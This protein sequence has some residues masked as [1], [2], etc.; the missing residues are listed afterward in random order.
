MVFPLIPGA[1][2][3]A[4]EPLALVATISYRPSPVQMTQN[5][6][7]VCGGR[8]IFT[9][10]LRRSALEFSTYLFTGYYYGSHCLSNPLFPIQ[11]SGNSID[12][13]L[14]L[15]RPCNVNPKVQSGLHHA[16]T[17][18]RSCLV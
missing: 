15:I 8:P 14:R 5:V 17:G 11:S 6:W 3:K 9:L 4:G 16:Q 12:Q 2:N 7:S 1:L 10:V 13:G 18:A